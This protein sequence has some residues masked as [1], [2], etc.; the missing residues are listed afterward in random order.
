MP[1]GSGV[2]RKDGPVPVKRGARLAC[3]PDL[4]GTVGGV[5]LKLVKIVGLFGQ[6]AS[7]AAGGHLK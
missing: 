3:D 1:H 5:T 7:F 2:G 6:F 4:P